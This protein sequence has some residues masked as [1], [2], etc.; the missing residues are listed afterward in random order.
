[1]FDKTNGQVP[2]QSVVMMSIHIPDTGSPRKMSWALIT[3]GMTSM[4]AA[5]V[6]A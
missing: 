6:C 5:R 3:P 4:G 1:M 2:S